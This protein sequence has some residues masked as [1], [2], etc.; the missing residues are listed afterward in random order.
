VQ[1]IADSRGHRLELANEPLPELGGA[2]AEASEPKAKEAK[3]AQRTGE[4]KRCV[5]L[6]VYS[7]DLDF[8]GGCACALLKVDEVLLRPIRSA[9]TAARAAWDL[10]RQATDV[11][12][13]SHANPEFYDY[14][15]RDMCQNTVDQTGI[16]LESGMLL[17]EAVNISDFQP[18]RVE[19][20]QLVVSLYPD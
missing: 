3:P 13:W 9:E 5:F 7:S 15:L 4:A 12:F 19:C 6:E 18:A 16:N 20:R 10:D 14:E 8:D 1:E 11:V 2:S 17:P